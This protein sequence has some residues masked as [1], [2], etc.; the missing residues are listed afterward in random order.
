VEHSF[1][2]FP[3][4]GLYLVVDGM[5]GSGRVSVEAAELILEVAR[6]TYEARGERTASALV[7]ALEAA[8]A[9][10]REKH[11]A[12]RRWFGTG[13]SVAALAFNAGDV[14]VAHVGDCRAYRF[15]GGALWLATVDH[16]LENDLA[17]K[18]DLSAEERARFAT[19]LVRALGMK[20]PCGVDAR[21]LDVQAGDRY[22]LASNGLGAFGDEAALA[23][24]LGRTKR[25]DQ[26]VATLIAGAKHR[27]GVDNITALVVDV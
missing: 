23:G 19:V 9:A 18:P 4:F 17:A 3:E 20:E 8:N 16:S 7:V 21:T 13:A 27:G 15:R 25:P 6:T 12:D 22:L 26:L 24:A 11:E 2:S 1:G 10:L 5:G 14:H